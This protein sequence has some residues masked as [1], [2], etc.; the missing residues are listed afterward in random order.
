MKTPDKVT[1]R[2]WYSLDQ[3]APKITIKLTATNVITL[4]KPTESPLALDIVVPELQ[5][6]SLQHWTSQ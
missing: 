5:R 3:S 6:S 1:P 4:T 2:E